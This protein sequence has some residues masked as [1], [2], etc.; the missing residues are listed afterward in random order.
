MWRRALV[1]TISDRVRIGVFLVDSGQRIPVLCSDLRRLKGIY[2]KQAT[3]VSLCKL[4]GVRPI[5]E[6]NIWPENSIYFFIN[7]VLN[8]DVSAY[9]E[10]VFP[11]SV[12]RMTLSK[13]MV[14]CVIMYVLSFLRD[15]AIV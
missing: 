4:T 6:G 12:G 1:E 14:A 9:V 13:E 15:V 3:R 2:M 5:A 8:A 7:K 11:G 10:H